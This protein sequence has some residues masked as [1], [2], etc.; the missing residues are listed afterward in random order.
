MSRIKITTLTPVHIG[1]GNMLQL[2][3]EFVPTA[4]LQ[5]KY[6]RIIDDRK[7]LELV[8][9]EHLDDWL[10]SIEKQ[11]DIKEFVKRYAPQSK[12]ADYSKRRLTSFVD[13]TTLKQG[14]TLKECIH[15]GF[16][17]PYIPGSSIKGAMRTAILTSLVNT[18]PNIESNIR[19][20]REKIGAEQIEKRL[21]GK[22]PNADVFRFLQ[23]GDAYFE[24]GS[25]IAVQL[26]MGLNITH[27]TEN[28]IPK[29]NKKPQLVEAIGV[30]EEALFQLKIDKQHYENAKLANPNA[31]G[32]MPQEMMSI[33][34]LFGLINSYTCTLIEKEINIW[35]NYEERTGADKYIE[36]MDEILSEARRCQSDECVLRIGHAS[37]WRFITGAW[38]EDLPNFNSTIVNAARPNNRNY[39]EYIFPKSR[40]TDSD[41]DLI[42]FVKLKAIKDE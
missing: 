38:A 30:E 9:E 1:S 12:V 25:E 15:N 34:S 3:T 14:D 5:E 11:E 20:K 10:L 23:V 13:S 36:K 26:V 16:G 21:F 22:D 17:L 41:G 7:V 40:R 42:G 19:D 31:I 33:N 18:I 35:K 32:E 37:G 24:Q 6:I 28:L 29:E 4:T 39:D 27:N 8:G 2:N